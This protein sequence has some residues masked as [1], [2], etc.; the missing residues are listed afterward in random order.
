MNIVAHHQKV[1]RSVDTQKKVL[2]IIH[3][4]VVRRAMQSNDHAYRKLLF[5]HADELAHALEKMNEPLQRQPMHWKQELE[6]RI[7]DI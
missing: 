7:Y 1:P 3:K 6:T 5:E 4:V 2:T